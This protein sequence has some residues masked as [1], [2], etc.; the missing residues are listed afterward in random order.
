MDVSSRRSSPAASYRRRPAPRRRSG[1]ALTFGQMGVI[2]MAHGEFLM[3][4]AYTAYLTQQVVTQRRRLAAAGAPGR[5]SWSAGLL[6][7]LLE[8]ARHP[9]D[10][11]PAAGH[12]AGHLR[13]RAWSSSRLAKDLFG[14]QADGGRGPELAG[15]ADPRS[16]A[17]TTR[18]RRLFIIVLAAGLPGRR[19][20]A[21]EVHL[22]RPA[23]P[24]H[25]PEPRPR[26][27]RRRLDP[28]R[29]TGSRSSSARAWPASPAS[30]SRCIT[31]TDSDAGHRPTSSPAFLVV[32][33]GG[34]GQIK[35]T[36]IAA[37]GLGIAARLPDLLHR[38][39]HGAG[40]DLRCWSWSSCSSD[41][42]ASSRSG[43]GAWHERASAQA[44][45]DPATVAAA[46]PPSRVAAARRRARRCSSDFRLNNLGK[47]CC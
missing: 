11:P 32:V 22:V 12:A 1:L 35:G 42:R 37:F 2:N 13:R 45:L 27:D 40:P 39:E 44:A 4:G 16:S 31:A 25:R 29:S 36:V 14:A 41:P 7:L 28:A 33:A 23:D 24:R 38:R 8:C 34:I 9:L 43:P 26:R 5:P 10:V 47:Y 19:R 18:S 17:T 46:S 6:G 30:R 20:G 15:R 21:A 3:A